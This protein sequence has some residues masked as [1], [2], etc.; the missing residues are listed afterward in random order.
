MPI[1]Y[2]ITLIVA[3]LG[4][5]G[6]TTIV[7]HQ[8]HKNDALGLLMLDY[9]KYRCEMHI[10]EGKITRNDYERL[11]KLY[12]KY[13]KKK[14]GNGNGYLSEYISDVRAL[15]DNNGKKK[16]VSI[17]TEPAT[18][19]PTILAAD[20]TES[21]C[22]LIKKALSENYTV[23]TTTNPKEVTTLLHQVRPELIILDNLMGEP[24]G[25]ELAQTI[26]N[27]PGHRT[28]PIIMLTGCTEEET[29]KQAYAAGVDEYI[30]KPFDERELQRVVG[31]ILRK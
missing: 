15:L 2:I 10:K 17:S 4:S 27:L 21:W 12:E 30:K 14:G 25:I 29:I 7:M 5:G 8:I 3:V 31:R 22:Y 20:D 6:V 1:E 16:I 24:S 28:T 13:S 18:T 9:I 23:H 26:R 11:Y 19:K